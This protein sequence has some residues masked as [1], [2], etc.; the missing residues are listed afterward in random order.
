MK[1]AVVCG[2]YSEVIKRIP[3]KSIDLIVTDPPY[4]HIKGGCKNKRLNV[5]CRDANSKVVSEMSDFGKAQIYSFLDAVKC[6]M[7]KVNMYVFASKLQLPYY[8]NWALENKL[9]FD[10]L[11]WFK[12]TT[13]MISTKFYASNVEYIVRIYTNGCSLNNITKENGKADSELYQ[14]FFIYDSPSKSKKLCETQKPLEMI[15]RIIRLSS[16]EG[17]IILDPFMGSGTMGVAC[18]NLGRSFIGIDTDQNIC[19]VAKDRIQ[20]GLD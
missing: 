1:L 18:R 4:L 20:R 10:V 7:K 13:R 19:D 9:Q 6:K 14:K 17:D 16:K 11:F 2:D 15:E 5:G 12:N 8:L 3:N